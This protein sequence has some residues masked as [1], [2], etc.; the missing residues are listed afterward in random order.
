MRH[1]R[2]LAAP[3]ALVLAL[4]LVGCAKN[5]NTV[6]QTP[7]QRVAVY[8]GVL[9]ESNNALTSGVIQLQKSG[10]LTTN[11]T[12]QVLDY[13]ERVANASKAVAI[14]QQTPGDWSVDA[15]QIRVVLMAVSPPGNFSAWLSDPQ[16]KQVLDSL[17]GLQNALQIILAEVAK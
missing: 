1:N 12:L 8:N 15:A 2:K 5:P 16:S 7:F 13:T 3:V 17:G 14:I 11:Q 4:L 10:V 6:P 9:A